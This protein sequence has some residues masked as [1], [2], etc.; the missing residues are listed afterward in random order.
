MAIACPTANLRAHL[1]V[2]GGEHALHAGGGAVG[3]GD[4]VAGL[5]QLE[6]AIQ[7]TGCGL[8]AYGK[9]GG[10]CVMGT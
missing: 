1:H 10:R 3:R 4:D 2:A 7:E 9:G 5:V 8:V 6:L